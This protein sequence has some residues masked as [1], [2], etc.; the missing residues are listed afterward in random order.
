MFS[1]LKKSFKSFLLLELL[2]GLRVTWK[3]FLGKGITIH[4]PEEKI[5]KSFRFRGLHALMCY[6]NGEERCIGC[7]L[8]EIVCP[9]RAI[10]METGINKNGLRGTISYEIDLFKCIF[11]GYCE[12]AC[13]VDS[14]VETG[15][16]EYHF[17]DRESCVLTK[18]KLLS[19]GRKFKDDIKEMKKSDSYYR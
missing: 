4:Y 12:E 5:P 10:T 15:I 6:D 17:Y 7:K 16:S 14:I 9:A 13:P 19:I 3:H 1:F 8:C 11:C 2:Q 18:E